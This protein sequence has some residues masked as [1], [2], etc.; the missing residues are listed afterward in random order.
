MLPAILVVAP[1]LAW[2]PT[3]HRAVGHI[4]QRH[5]SPQTRAAI[6]ALMGPESL[7]RASTWPDEIRS[8]PAWREA[9][10]DDWRQHFINA[11]L[12]E[13][14][15]FAV[16][17]VP[18]PASTNIYTAIQRYEAVLADRRA[19]EEDR[20]VAL[21]WLVHL[22]GD[23][24]QPLHAGSG[25]DRGANR[26]TVAWF[27]E[28]TN[29]HTVWDER[30][31]QHTELSY[32]ELVDFIDHPTAAQITEWQAAP[33]TTWLEESRALLPACYE[34]GDGWLSYDYAWRHTP[35]VERRLLQAGVR[36]AGQLD[37][38]LGEPAGKPR[39]RRRR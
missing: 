9:A 26:V 23:A 30:L 13:P 18:S 20:R 15:S 32:T 5:V 1:A 24:H 10:P 6:E 29:L 35:T 12:G 37:R 25:E 17:D 11:P 2:G 39:K 16:P 7:A 36:L 19:P 21:R 4:A 8:D 14:L 38:V 33:V 31:I 22:A 28:K 34:T 3:G 27:D